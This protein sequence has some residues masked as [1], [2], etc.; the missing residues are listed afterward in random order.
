MS[1][2]LLLQLA[3]F[4]AVE[5]VIGIL[6]TAPNTA[7]ALINPLLY[8][9]TGSVWMLLPFTARIWSRVPG[10]AT[11]VG[12]IAGILLVP[13]NALGILLP[14]SLAGQGLLF[15]LVLWRSR[16]P[17]PLRLG[18]AAALTGTVMGLASLPV[19]DS[20]WFSAW[21]VV[22]IVALRCVATVTFTF[23]ASLL[24]RQLL[25]RGVM[26][27]RSKGTDLPHAIDRG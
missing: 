7:I 2:R 8:A 6:I 16:Q 1:T 18:I 3:A 14:L 22:A 27:I 19:I 4:A 15:D 21:F 25:H 23:V 20:S 11:A 12:V 26:P 24:N 17:S 10:T 13:F 9:V 5:C